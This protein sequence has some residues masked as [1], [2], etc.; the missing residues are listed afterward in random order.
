MT[1]FKYYC[2]GL[3]VLKSKDFKKNLIKEDSMIVM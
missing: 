1:T 3:P 2:K